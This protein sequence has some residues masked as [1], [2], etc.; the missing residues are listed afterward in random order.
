MDQAEANKQLVFLHH[1]GNS[2]SMDDVIPG[3]DGI[4]LLPGELVL[5][6]SVKMPAL[7]GKALLQA[8]PY[9]CED[10]LSQAV[11]KLSLHRY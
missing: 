3:V 1:N 8:L 11:E 5:T 7:K 10:K 4:A 6:F 9:A 2:W